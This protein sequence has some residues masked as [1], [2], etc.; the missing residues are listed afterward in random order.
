MSHLKDSWP[1]L[2]CLGLLVTPLAAQESAPRLL[3]VDL[4]SGHKIAGMPVHW[5]QV[6]AAV[7]EPSGFFH[8]LDLSK[9]SS[10]RILDTS[11]Q[12]QSLQDARHRLQR[13]LG[14]GFD[15]AIAGPYVIAAPR[16][17]AQQWQRRF[18]ALY[19]GY[20]RYFDTR[21]WVW[22]PPDFPLVVVVFP[23]R[24]A[25]FNYAQSQGNRLPSRA[26]GSY[27]PKSNRCILYQI[28]G[29]GGT[30]WHETEATIVHEAVHQLAY[31][32]GGHERLF[33]NPVWFV[34]G[35]ATMFERPAVYDT[36]TNQRSL[37]VRAHPQKLQRI[38]PLMSD[39]PRLAALMQD[40]VNRDEMFAGDAQ[41][42]YAL[43]W[44]MTFYLTE[45]MPREY[46]QYVAKLNQRPFGSYTQSE[47]K[48]D[49]EST[50]RISGPQLANQMSRFYQEL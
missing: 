17:Q 50:F 37:L 16:R 7:I 30:D 39:A 22:R 15:T 19:S 47:R 18:L 46:G 3:E 13:E 5:G 35:L 24:E 38:A 9:V 42:A 36:G 48:R 14:S 26:V 20:L 6:D 34:E 1:W 12:P 45:R 25:F 10:H 2:I 31:N 49:F 28:P 43:S 23:N 29:A 40:L 8:L 4:K 27:F 21:G 33:A 44:G 32:T 11:F 41:L